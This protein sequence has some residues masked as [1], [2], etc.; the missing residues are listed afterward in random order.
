MNRLEWFP[1]LEE[2]HERPQPF[3]ICVR[4]E[5]RILEFFRLSSRTG[6]TS[7]SSAENQD[8]MFVIHPFDQEEN[9]HFYGLD[10]IDTFELFAEPEGAVQ[11]EFS[12]SPSDRQHYA[13]MVEKALVPL[14]KGEMKKVVLSSRLSKP[15]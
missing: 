11:G 15:L 13:S 6:A 10:P 8:E 9:A 14:R 7:I 1:L 3:L 12:L 2:L 4:P 5:S